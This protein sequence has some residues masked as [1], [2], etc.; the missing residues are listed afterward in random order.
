[1]AL[2]LDTLDEVGATARWTA[3]ARA[4]ERERPDALLDDPW[5]ARLAGED[6]M[7]W[8]ARQAPGATLPMVLRAR[9]FDEWLLRSFADGGPRQAVLLGAGLDT[10]AWR[11]LWPIGSTVFEVDHACALE[12]KAC[13]LDE[14]RAVP[15]CR[16]MS[17]G[18]DL[19]GAWEAALLDV[20]FDPSRPTSWLAEGLLFYLPDPLLRDVLAR[21]T[22]RSAPGSRLGFDIPNRAVLSSPW[23]QTWIEMQS[24]AGAPWLGTMDDPATELAALGWDATVSQPGEG[25]SGH[26]RWTLPV[27][28]AGASALPHSWYVTAVRSS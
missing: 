13:M 16:R 21:I 4:L 19:A 25:D 20:G 12:R 24:A 10:R 9:F 11:L 8:L 26:G 6:G 1:M 28:P 7:A 27:L 2:L 22:H 14:A 3:A 15:A 5:A 17:V 23:T 18:A